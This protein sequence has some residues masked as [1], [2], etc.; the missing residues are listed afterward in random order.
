MPLVNLET[1]RNDLVCPG[2]FGLL[3]EDLRKCASCSLEFPVV[4]GKPVLVNFESSVLDYEATARTTGGSPVIRSKHLPNWALKILQGENQVAERQSQILLSLARQTCERPRVLVVG[5]GSVG[6]GL[7]PLY[8]DQSVDLIA[9]DLYSSEFVQFV[10]DA[11]WIPLRDECVDGVLIQAVL[12][13]VLDPQRVVSEIERV[14]RPNGLVYADTP[15]LQH[16]HEGAYDFTRFTESGHRYLFKN[17]SEISAGVVAGPSVQMIWSIDSLCRSLFR[18][19][20]AGLLA[21]AAFFWLRWLDR[22]VPAEYAIDGASACYFF[23]RKSGTKIAP[24]ELVKRY[25]GAQR[26]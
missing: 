18:S 7:H 1:F 14:L 19:R 15:F 22:L 10:A 8:A 17:F 6:S 25:R 20:T 21:R 5:G 9:F 13:H 24:N 3:T 4:Q 2:C 11:H 16:V 26:V 23:G 12:E